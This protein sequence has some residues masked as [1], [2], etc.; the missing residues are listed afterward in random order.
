MSSKITSLTK[1]MSP[2]NIKLVRLLKGMYFLGYLPITWKSV[3]DPDQNDIFFKNSTIKSMLII[4]LDVIIAMSVFV[5]FYVWHLI[6]MGKD[7]DISQ[8]WTLNYIVGIYDGRVT[9]A[10]SQFFFILFPA[11]LFGLYTFIGKVLLVQS[12]VCKV[13]FCNT[14][15]SWNLTNYGFRQILV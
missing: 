1:Q 4:I 15:T 6:N 3:Q 2:K 10:L 11:L 5:F 9:T 8:I 13:N 7:F 14:Y 12:N